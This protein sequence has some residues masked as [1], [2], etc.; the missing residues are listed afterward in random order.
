MGPACRLVGSPFPI[1]SWTVKHPWSVSRLV[2]QLHVYKGVRKAAGQ[3]K[4]GITH[5]RRHAVKRIPNTPGVAMTMS[6]PG[7]FWEVRKLV[8]EGM[9]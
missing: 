6:R 3:P 7:W 4:V 2:R 1:F 9:E 8:L 5:L